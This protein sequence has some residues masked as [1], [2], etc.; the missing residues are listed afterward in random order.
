M[1]ENAVIDF[2]L[3]YEQLAIFAGAFIFGE[4]V[5]IPAA[6]LSGQ[7]L[8]TPFNVFWPAFLGTVVSDVFWFLLARRFTLKISEW[9]WL[10]AESESRRRF[11]DKFQKDNFRIAFFYKFFYGMRIAAIASF[12]LK[13]MTLDK[14]I[15]FDSLST[16]IWLFVIVG[17]G[18]LAGRGLV[19]VLETF[20][21]LTYLVAAIVIL[22][23]VVKLITLWLAKRVIKK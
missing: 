10:R 6:F 21:K 19:N 20:S 8:W 4:N 12:S 22:I 14:F 11:I 7:G 23:I 5:I 1:P 9:R 3:Q 13:G 17:I 18:W 15:R 16:L 2:L